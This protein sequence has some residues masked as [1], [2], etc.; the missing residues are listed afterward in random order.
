M[1]HPVPNGSPKS[2]NPSLAV[3]WSSPTCSYAYTHARHHGTVYCNFYCCLPPSSESAGLLCYTHRSK[4]PL[5]SPVWWLFLPKNIRPFDCPY[6]VSIKS[7]RY[8]WTSPQVFPWRVHI[9]MKRAAGAELQ[10]FKGSRSS[11][12]FQ[13]F[14]LDTKDAMSIFCCTNRSC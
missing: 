5:L 10:K 12:N 13:S 14:A 8:R 1:E 2:R 9:E 3:H 11:D 4:K 7:C 6:R